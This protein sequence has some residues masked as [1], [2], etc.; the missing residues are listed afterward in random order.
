MWPKTDIA[1][2]PAP[3]PIRLFNWISIMVLL[4]VCVLFFM[5]FVTPV[6]VSNN[7]LFIVILSGITL[8]VTVILFSV[9]L[10]I[11]GLEEEKV[12]IWD[13]QIKKRDKQW[14]EWSMQSLAVLG[15]VVIT[16]QDLSVD[17]LLKNQ[18]Q[19]HFS[20]NEVFSF[21]KTNYRF[22]LES[23]EWIFA[24]FYDYLNQIGDSYTLTVLLLGSPEYHTEQTRLIRQAYKQLEGN[25]PI[26]FRYHSILGAE[27]DDINQLIDNEEPA[28]YLIIADN[29][30]STDSSAFMS[31]L[32]L[33]N[34]SLYTNIPNLR[35]QS[36]V[37]RP[38]QTNRDEL[39]T[40]IAQ[41]H[42]IQPAFSHIQQL[43]YSQ[44]DEKAVADLRIL[45]FE[46][47]IILREMEYPAIYP[48]DTYFGHPNKVLS[49]WLLL[50][51][52]T[53]AVTKTQQTQLVAAN[54]LDKLLFTVVSPTID[55]K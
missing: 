1:K 47:D 45:F 5:L 28:L 37:L 23:Y 9:R 15:S 26:E 46:Y 30:Q 17:D 39:S 3:K 20:A 49:Y 51:L 24:N 11:Y 53:Q 7:T 27:Q 18:G 29:V 22:Y 2:L 6:S 43:W 12:K 38:M 13:E 25:L 41:M 16:P 34:E 8:F 50:A 44:F 33:A 40:A 48:L 35:A 52:T 21:S 54:V 4:L 55:D 31:A 42:E 10:F 19:L 14:Q 36:Y 32:L